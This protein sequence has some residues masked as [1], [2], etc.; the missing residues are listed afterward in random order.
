MLHNKELSIFYNSIP[1]SFVSYMDVLSDTVIITGL[2][3]L[4]DSRIKILLYWLSHFTT[5][6]DALSV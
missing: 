1:Y 3:E 4:C 5:D 2:S 6:Y